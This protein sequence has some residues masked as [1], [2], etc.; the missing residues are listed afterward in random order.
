MVSVVTFG[1]V[2]DTDTC[3]KTGRASADTWG[4]AGPSGPWATGIVVLDER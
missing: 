2:S 4:P 1:N 3:P